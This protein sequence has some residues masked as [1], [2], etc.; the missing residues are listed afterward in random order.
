MASI[1]YQIIQSNQHEEA[2]TFYYEHFLTQDPVFSCF[3]SIQR[4]P[5]IDN[6]VSKALN[7]NECWCAV[8]ETSDEIISICLCTSIHEADLVD[9]NQQ[10]PK[11]EEY[12]AQGL[13]EGLAYV[14]FA[15]RETVSIKQIMNDYGVSQLVLIGGV[16]VHPD[17]QRRGIATTLFERAINHAVQRDY[18]LCVVGCSSLYTQKLSEKLGFERINELVMPSM[19]KWFLKT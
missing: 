10:P 9:N 12:L 3:G 17:Y 2:L 15:K 19:E 16:G 8:D 1:R 4:H 5:Y 11:L 6:Y 13:P 14:E 18:H 7:Q